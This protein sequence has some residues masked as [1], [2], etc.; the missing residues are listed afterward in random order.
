MLLSVL[1][2]FGGQESLLKIPLRAQ[3]Q[4]LHPPEPHCTSRVAA[5]HGP[6]HSLVVSSAWKGSFLMPWLL[7]EGGEGRLNW[8]N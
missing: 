5:V 1:T 4:V 7:V 6:R 8:L 3:P 2:G